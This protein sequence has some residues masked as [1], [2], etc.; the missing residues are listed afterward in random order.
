MQ[1]FD[2]NAIIPDFGGSAHGRETAQG[3]RFEQ[4]CRAV[5]RKAENSATEGKAI[6]RANGGCLGN[7]S[8]NHL[9]V[10]IRE[11]STAHSGLAQNR[12]S[13]K[14]FKSASDFTRRIENIFANFVKISLDSFYKLCKYIPV[15]FKTRGYNKQELY[16]E[17]PAFGLNVTNFG[18]EAGFLF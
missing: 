11:N 1:S 12:R 8:N 17:K 15:T 3:S 2:S 4:L 13:F 18:T 14:N 7:D 9:P 16:P 10:G 6:A 5:C